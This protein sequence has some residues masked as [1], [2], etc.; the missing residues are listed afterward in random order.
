MEALWTTI[1]RIGI[2]IG[3]LLAIPVFWTWYAVT[4]GA[5]R[6]QRRVLAEIRRSPGKRPAVLIVDLLVGKDVRAAVELFLVAQ[7][8]LAEIPPGRRVFV[9]RDRLLS[10]DEMPA[11]LREVRAVA[12]R[13]IADGVD[14]IHYFH[15]GPAIAAAVVGA[16]FANSARV[17]LYQHTD[18]AYLNFGPLRL[19]TA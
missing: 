5:R 13:L 15:A 17:L 9:Q 19:P 10:P 1:D 6:R 2:V 11:F 12:A 18:G 8:G 3:L 4:L 7:P 14:T 16:E